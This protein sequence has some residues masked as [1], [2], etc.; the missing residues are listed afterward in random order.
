MSFFS[1]FISPDKGWIIGEVDDL[2]LLKLTLK[3]KTNSGSERLS[4]YLSLLFAR[5][6]GGYYSL[7]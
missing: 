6:N 5:S 4:S 1:A 2:K 3:T 7:L